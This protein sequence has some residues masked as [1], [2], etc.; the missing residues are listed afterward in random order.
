MHTVKLM[1]LL[2]KYRIKAALQYPGSY[3]IGIVSQW[4]DYSAA[5]FSLY[6]MVKSFSS[7]NGWSVYEVMLLYGISLLSYA[8]GASLAFNVQRTMPQIASE[9]GLDEL[10]TKP[11]HPLINLIGGNFNA[12]YLSHVTLSVAVIAVAFIK[13]HIQL[14]VLKILW[15]CACILG[16]AMLH[17]AAMLCLSFYSLRHFGESPFDPLYWN[18]QDYTN[19][20]I[21]IFCKNSVIMQILF[22]VI[23]PYGFIAFYPSQYF[24]GKSDFMMFHPVIQY[25]TPAVGLLAMGLV[26]VYFNR[27]IKTYRSSGT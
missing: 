14:G 4:L 27:I 17:C 6:V 19:Y 8:I 20:P 26:V 15:L 25:L 12:G 2:I 13:L 16:A 18:L 23:L 3:M 24:L 22:T 1:L 10:L 7:L 11:L 21:S 9:G 5:A